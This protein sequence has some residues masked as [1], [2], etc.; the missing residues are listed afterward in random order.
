MKTIETQVF[1]FD[2]L[3]DKA[4]EKARGWFRQDYDSSDAADYILDDA[5]TIGLAIKSLS[6]HRANKGAFTDDAVTCAQAIIENHGPDC[7]TYKTAKAFLL[8]VDSLNV[9]YPEYAEGERESDYEDE[10]EELEKEFLGSLLSD[11]WQMLDKEIEYQNSEE[12]VDENIT[13]NDYTFTEDGKR[14]G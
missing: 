14:F 1:T 2:E 10:K 6:Q 8:S 5:K 11:Y 9:E 4:K 13:A 7:E 12:V 3:S